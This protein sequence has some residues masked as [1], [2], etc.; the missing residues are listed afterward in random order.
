MRLLFLI[1]LAIVILGAL[2]IFKISLPGF[3]SGD[4]YQYAITILGGLVT[5]TGL[6]SSKNGERTRIAKMFGFKEG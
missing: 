2:P 1:G 3:I 4:N 6:F 5:L